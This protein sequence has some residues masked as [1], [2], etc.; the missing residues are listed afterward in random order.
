LTVFGSLH[1]GRNFKEKTVY[2]TGLNG[3]GSS[4]VNALSSLFTVTSR[5]NKEYGS[6][7]FI[8]GTDSK[9]VTGKIKNE[10]Q[11]DIKTNTGT[12]VQFKFDMKIFNGEV[13]NEMLISYLKEVAYLNTNLKVIFLDSTKPTEKELVFHYTNNNHG[14]QN[15]INDLADSFSSENSKSSFLCEPVIFSKTVDDNRVEVAFTYSSNANNRDENIISF[16]NTIKTSDGGTHVTGFKRSFTQNLLEYITTNKLNG[17]VN[18]E[19][20]DLKSGLIVIVSVF[21]FNPKYSSQTKQKLT[22]TN[23][24][25]SVTKVCNE[26]IKDWTSKNGKVIKALTEVFMLNAKGRIA[27]QKAL[28]QV[29]KESSTFISSVNDVNKYAPCIESGDHCELFIVEGDSGKGSVEQGRNKNNQAVF[30][31]KGKPLNVLLTD[32]NGALSNKEISDLTTIM[33]CGYGDVLKT[34]KLPF[35]KIII[36]SD[37]D[38]DGFHIQIL[39]M[40]VYN[41]LFKQLIKEGKVYIAVP[42]LYRAVKTNKP[43]IYITNDQEL[44]KFYLKEIETNF[45]IKINNR[46]RILTKENYIHSIQSFSKKLSMVALKYG[47]KPELFEGILINSYNDEYWD[48][49][50]N[51]STEID[52]DNNLSVNGFVTVSGKEEFFS[53]NKVPYNDLVD[54]VN[55][56]LETILNL[57]I[58]DYEIEIKYKGNSFSKDT[59]YETFKF[60]EQ[61]SQSYTITRFKGLGE[62]NPDELYDTTLNP[63]KRTLIKLVQTEIDDEVTNLL[64]SKKADPKKEFIKASFLKDTNLEELD[65]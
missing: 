12:S 22:N 15:Y 35:G 27:Q 32:I 6:I 24:S 65:I 26:F 37:A 31:V 63:E 55:N 45:E 54:D 46:N 7:A 60:M 29:K 40:T 52:D 53:L 51:L 64:M 48:F 30:A 33:K 14:L 44:A 4:V 8:E 13:T 25:G 1:S 47:L 2:S 36:L 10:S 39:L 9:V 38:Y 58:Y 49:D 41:T 34:E 61:M 50:E 18:L 5:R 21:T 57:K 17:K 56:L 43:P 62:A 28:E 16:C 3:V 19:A 59:I 42:P 11:L 23:V 20:D